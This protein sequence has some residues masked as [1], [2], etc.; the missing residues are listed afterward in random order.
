VFHYLHR[1]LVFPWQLKTRNKK[2]PIVIMIFGVFFNFMNGFV[3]GYYFGYLSP[4]YELSWFYD[5][6]F[7]AGVLVFAA[8]MYINWQS[9]EILLKLRKTG[10][11]GY[12]IPFGFM[13]KYISCPNYFGEMLE[14]MGFALMAWCLPALTF[15]LWT[16][17]NLL[18]RAL[19][20]HKWY[21]EQFPEYP[22]ERKAVVP[23]I[24]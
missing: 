24:L 13:Y 7:I 4:Q 2:M 17:V 1:D 16:T 6:R 5:P 14:W 9:D 11:T 18:P 10:E 3:N 20:H 19:A 22:K 15:S 8:G 23:F 12:K 21:Q